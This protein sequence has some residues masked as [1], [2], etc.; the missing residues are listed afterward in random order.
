VSRI[1]NQSRASFLTQWK[2]SIQQA[3]LT[4]RASSLDG[5]V[6]DNEPEPEAWLHEVEKLRDP[7]H[8]RVLT[9]RAWKELCAAAG[10][11]VRWTDIHVKKQ[12]DLKWY[13]ETAGTSQENRRRVLK[14][15]KDTPASARR[16]FKL[17]SEDG[18]ISWQWPMLI[19]IAQKVRVNIFQE[20]RRSRIIETKLSSP[21]WIWTELVQCSMKAR[22]RL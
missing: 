18:K 16:V 15:I 19:L 14:L 6:T 2:S 10:L 12:P 7:S 17:E 3:L 9:S 8:Q 1:E 20:P 4:P 5:T 22:G 13:F 21:R 11:T